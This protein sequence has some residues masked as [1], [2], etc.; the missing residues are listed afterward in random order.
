MSR[1]L[2]RPSRARLSSLRHP[3]PQFFPIKLHHLT[4]DTVIATKQQLHAR[5]DAGD[6]MRAAGKGSL[7]ELAEARAS[8]GSLSS[9][10]RSPL[11]RVAPVVAVQ[12]LPQRSLLSHFDHLQFQGSSIEVKQSVLSA[13]IFIRPQLGFWLRRKVSRMRRV[14]KGWDR[15]APGRTRD[16][17]PWV[18][19][20]ALAEHLSCRGLWEMGAAAWAPNTGSFSSAR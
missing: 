20:Y 7:A 15:E 10:V 9:R 19:N 14:L 13:V 12:N 18:M 11:L 4:K 5:H 17:I 6:K 16:P 3:Q 1:T 2:T 8:T